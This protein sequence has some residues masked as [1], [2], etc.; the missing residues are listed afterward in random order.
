[1]WQRVRVFG[2]AF[3][4]Y[5]E[6]LIRQEIAKRDLAAEIRRPGV[7]V[8]RSLI[9]PVMLAACRAARLAWWAESARMV[10]ADTFFHSVGRRARVRRR[11]IRPA[12]PIRE[13]PRRSKEGRRA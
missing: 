5:F 1:M 4:G 3:S 7:L 8:A 11:A 10:S 2:F 6:K 12:E 9:G 13:R